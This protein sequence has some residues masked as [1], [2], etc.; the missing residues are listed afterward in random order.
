[1]P[2]AREN[3][4]YLANRC[5]LSV[6]TYNYRL[7]YMLLLYTSTRLMDWPHDWWLLSVG[8]WGWY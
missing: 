8:C 4:T 1:M 6:Q 3:L 7:N 2:S 5:S